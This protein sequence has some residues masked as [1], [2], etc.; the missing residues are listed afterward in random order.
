MFVGMDGS[1][2]VTEI[3]WPSVIEY[4][5]EAAADGVLVTNL[6]T[7]DRQTDLPQGYS[8]EPTIWPS[9][10]EAFR[11]FAENGDA[12]ELV[13]KGYEWR[14][15]TF[16][17]RLEGYRKKIEK[18][19][20]DPRSGSVLINSCLSEIKMVGAA[21]VRE[22]PQPVKAD[23]KKPVEHDDVASR[24]ARAHARNFA[25]EARSQHKPK[26]KTKGQSML[27]DGFRGKDGSVQ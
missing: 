12:W 3:H 9:K 4:C 7:E 5:Q 21:S 25:N 13:R 2:A 6:F 24:L 8:G 22:K 18:G 19:S 15:L 17:D 1:F 11:H 20:L 16:Y 27:P 10:R 23:A 26:R 14:T